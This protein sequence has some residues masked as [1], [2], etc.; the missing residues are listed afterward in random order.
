[1]FSHIF[2]ARISE[3]LLFIYI[4]TQNF[5]FIISSNRRSHH[6]IRYWTWLS[7]II[8]L[9]LFNFAYL[10]WYIAWCIS[11][12]NCQTS[13]YVIDIWF[14]AKLIII[15]LTYLLRI[16]LI[17]KTS[18]SSNWL[19]QR[20]MLLSWFSKRPW[21]YLDLRFLFLC[22]STIHHKWSFLNT[23]WSINSL[24]ISLILEF[25]MLLI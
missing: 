14:Y 13:N 2:K 1:M 11:L 7:L 25:C 18:S 24:M 6:S 19:F 3:R 15:L 8:T 23:F 9:C 10:R 12:L 17:R 5:L 21:H 20:I 22:W 4:S 16:N